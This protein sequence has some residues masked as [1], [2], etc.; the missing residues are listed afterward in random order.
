MTRSRRSGIAPSAAL[1]CET[2][3]AGSRAG[4]PPSGL[5][6]VLG[7]RG[8][9]GVGPVRGLEAPAER[10]AAL[11]PARHEEPRRTSTCTACDRGEGGGEVDS[12][13]GLIRGEPC[14]GTV[15]DEAVLVAVGAVVD[16][17]LALALHS[18]VS[19]NSRSLNA[20]VS[21]PVNHM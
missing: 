7:L 11:P 3:H 13:Y 12:G 10:V 20:R 16:Q 5:S 14:E 9:R 8:G 2:G 1:R 6:P 15:E 19:R 18:G 21:I 4:A 17:D